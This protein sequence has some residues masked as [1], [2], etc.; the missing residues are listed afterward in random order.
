MALNNMSEGVG[1]KIVEAL[2]MQDGA[3][4]ENDFLSDNTFNSEVEREESFGV[5]NGDL[6]SDIN[7][8]AVSVSIEPTQSAIDS[9]FEQSLTNTLGSVNIADDFD[10]P[11]NVA[12][13]KQLIAKLPSGV[14]KQT[15]A[16]IIK[17]TMEALG[18]SMSSV[19]Q[20]AKQVQQTFVNNSRDCQNNI[21]ECR[22]QIAILEAK[23]Q[24]YQKQS[25]VMNDIIN[26][27]IQASG[28]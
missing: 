16:L 2:K 3:T 8:G 4:L 23:A 18:I 7:N 14:S 5:G 21:I 20:E 25:A 9:A 17:Q 28:R 24:Q 1:K 15:G 12:V 22:K 27:F 19:L 6:A 13:L 26:L 10:Y 11:A